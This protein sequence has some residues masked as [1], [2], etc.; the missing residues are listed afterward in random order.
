MR[1]KPVDQRS[2]GESLPT[3]SYIEK[4]LTDVH[5][6]I[7]RQLRER[8]V[9]SGLASPKRTCWIVDGKME[10]V[11]PPHSRLRVLRHVH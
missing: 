6:I 7:S 2:L 3:L 8:D 1:R 4:S 5:R 11:Q 9:L 10:S